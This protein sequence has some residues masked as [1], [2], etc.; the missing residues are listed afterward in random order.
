MTDNL[1]V[2]L[3]ELQ[4]YSDSRLRNRSPE[5]DTLNSY[6]VYAKRE[7]LPKVELLNRG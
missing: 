1:N 3:S 6:N 7:G 5:A 2:E 4:E